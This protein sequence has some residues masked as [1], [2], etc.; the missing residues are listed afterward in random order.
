MGTK[1]QWAVYEWVI[2]SDDLVH[3]WVCF[4]KGQVYERGRFRNTGLHTRTKITPT[5]PPPP[6][7]LRD[8]PPRNLEP[9]LVRNAYET[10]TY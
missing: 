2:I 7:P 4:F 8:P 5:S 10:G 9:F 1:N 6:H 3:E